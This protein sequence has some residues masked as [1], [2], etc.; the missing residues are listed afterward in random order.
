MLLDP[1]GVAFPYSIQTMRLVESEL[2]NGVRVQ[3]E[4]G[5]TP[6]TN[7]VWSYAVLPIDSYAIKCLVPVGNGD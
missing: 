2:F 5:H 7:G 6:K 1:E 3:L 4:V